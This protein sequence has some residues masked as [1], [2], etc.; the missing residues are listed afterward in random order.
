[1]IKAYIDLSLAYP[2][3]STGYSFVAADVNSKE[4]CGI[5]YRLSHFIPTTRIIW[6]KE[7]HVNIR[8]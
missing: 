1:M 5:G 3:A 7:L 8:Q 6:M 4:E 2:D